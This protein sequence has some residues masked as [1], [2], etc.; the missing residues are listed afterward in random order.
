MMAAENA[1]RAADSVL[2]CPGCRAQV[3]VLLS[4]WVKWRPD[5]TDQ[6]HPRAITKDD[7]T[8]VRGEPQNGP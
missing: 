3:G 6:R 7:L 4:P 5:T 8:N 1:H 2:R